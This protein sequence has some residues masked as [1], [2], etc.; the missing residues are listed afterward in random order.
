MSDSVEDIRALWDEI[1]RLRSSIVTPH[2]VGARVYNSTGLGLTTGVGRILTFDSERFDTDSFHDTGSNTSRLTAPVAG[3][4]VVGAQV[5][6]QLG[7][8]GRRFVEI[9]LNGD[10]TNP[11]ER[12]EAGAVADA[13]S[14]PHLL[15]VTLWLA[16]AGDYFECRAFQSSGGNLNV[17]QANYLS[18]EFWCYLVG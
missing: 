18:P 15:A 3:Y 9:C 17:E 1:Y 2:F 13:T 5:R 10:T 8:G 16:A 11:L 14:T 12:V 4:Y 7:A 6:F